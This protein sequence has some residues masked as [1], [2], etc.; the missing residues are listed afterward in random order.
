MEFEDDGSGATPTRT[1]LSVSPAPS[2]QDVLAPAAGP[3]SSEQESFRRELFSAAPSVFVA[4]AAPGAV[5]TF[6]ATLRVV[7]PKVSAKIGARVLPV[8]TES[9][10]SSFLASVALPGPK[11]AS[12]VSA[13]PAARWSYVEVV[14]APTAYWRVV[15]GKRTVL[16]TDWFPLPW[17]VLVWY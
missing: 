3:L 9:E 6:E 13:Q 17:G 16:E 15:R 1:D 7:V 10:F 2:G 14:K 4:S 11:T 8:N 5:R 12:S